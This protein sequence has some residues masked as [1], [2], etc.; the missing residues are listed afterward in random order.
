[1]TPLAKDIL[2]LQSGEW[3]Y[4]GGLFHYGS[5]AQAGYEITS[6]LTPSATQCCRQCSTTSRGDVDCS[7]A[8]LRRYK[9]G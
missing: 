7:T 6:S 9:V 8:Q 2:L 4:G 1:M 5:D 3:G